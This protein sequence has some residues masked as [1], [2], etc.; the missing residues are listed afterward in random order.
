MTLKEI[1]HIARKKKPV[2]SKRYDNLMKLARVRYQDAKS[3]T[4]HR[5]AEDTLAREQR[6]KQL[7]QSIYG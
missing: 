2:D 5:Q 3:S 1:L 7:K 6:V 4:L